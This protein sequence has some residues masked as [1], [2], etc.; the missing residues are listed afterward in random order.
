M[1]IIHEKCNNTISK[2][3]YGQCTIIDS[4]LAQSAQNVNIFIVR[5]SCTDG[6]EIPM[7][8]IFSISNCFVFNAYK[9]I[10]FR[11]MP[12]AFLLFSSFHRANNLITSKQKN[13]HTKHSKTAKCTELRFSGHY[14]DFKHSTYHYAAE[15]KPY[16]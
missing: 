8:A 4:I 12:S 10:S 11:L 9:P 2:F 6:I 16:W 14:I 15:I 13:T 5:L 3:N 7:R 1:F